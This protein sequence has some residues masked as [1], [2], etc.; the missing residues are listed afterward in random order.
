M[1]SK[2]PIP[3]KNFQECKK[4]LTSDPYLDSVDVVYKAYSK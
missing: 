2:F 3:D 4:K 1:K